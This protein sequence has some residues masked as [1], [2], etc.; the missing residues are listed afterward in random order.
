MLTAINQI[1]AYKSAGY[2]LFPLDNWSNPKAPREKNYQNIDYTDETLPK[3][4]GVKLDFIDCVLDFDPRRGETQLVDLFRSIGLPRQETFMVTSQSGGRHVYYKM[5]PL[6][7]GYHFPAKVPGYPAIEIKS[8]GLYVVGAGS[9][10]TPPCKCE[11]SPSTCACDREPRPY[12]YYRHDPSIVMQLP[13]KLMDVLKPRFRDANLPKLG[14][15]TDDDA[16]KTQ[17]IQ[18]LMQPYA[19]K[20]GTYQNACEGRAYGLSPDAVFLLMA[21]YWNSRRE[22]PKTDEQLKQK[23]RNAYTYGQR[24]PG[25]LSPATIFAD[26]KPDAP[27]QKYQDKYPIKWV[28]KT[29]GGTDLMTC[30]QNVVNHFSLEKHGSEQVDNPFINMLGYNTH[31][32]NVEFLK[33][34]PWHTPGEDHDIWLDS[35]TVM[36]KN[37][38]GFVCHYR[39]NKEDIQ[40]AVFVVANRLKYNPIKID[41]ES[42]KWDGE[43]RLERLFV[44]YAKCDDTPY[45]R[46]VGKNMLIGLVARAYD[47]GCQHD[48]MVIVEGLQGIGKSSFCKSLGGKYHIDTPMV[49]GKD[50]IGIMRKG[51]LIEIPEMEFTSKH[52]VKEIRRHITCKEDVGRMPY[53][54]VTEAFKRASV[55][56]G[57]ANPEQHGYFTD[58]TGNRRF[59]PVW[60]YSIDLDALRRDRS[61]ILA[62]ALVR[63]KEGENHYLDTP[64]LVEMAKRQTQARMEH[65]PWEEDIGQWL[66]TVPSDLVLTTSTIMTMGLGVR[67]DKALAPRVSKIM[68]KLGYNVV[69]HRVN[70]TRI[71]VWEKDL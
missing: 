61:Q 8:K 58:S 1:S 54:R 40:D 65:D 6:Q 14:Y 37:Y 30:M 69:Q 59:E 47:P 64:E 71:R 22:S 63:Y 27:E 2:S 56:I 44:D 28:P 4:Y 16:T 57:T 15:F 42:T 50:G 25:S 3:I 38:L 60:A 9:I 48:T 43:N 12:T 45:S 21:D 66:N 68:A 17:F 35:D 70:G 24:E 41:I 19:M 51:W 13:D 49:T 31:S 5:P 52:E 34:A 10:Y 53:A 33:P 26:F 46:A 67:S 62:E 11:E 7:T 18:Y 36:C 20:V 29:P 32:S 55:F 39:A 23:I